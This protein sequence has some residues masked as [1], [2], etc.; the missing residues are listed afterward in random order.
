MADADPDL[1]DPKAPAGFWGVEPRSAEDDTPDINFRVLKGGAPES[2]RDL[3]SEAERALTIVKALYRRPEDAPKLR[4]AVAKLVA[5]SQVGLVGPNAS[6]AVA[7]DALRAL[8][9]DIIE[10]EAGPIKNQYMRKLGGWA[11]LFG[12][13][14]MV[15][16]LLCQH[17]PQ[18]LFE[19]F[20]RYR[21]VFLVW[22][23]SMAGAWASFASRKV[24]LGFADLVALEDDRIEPQLRLIFTGTLTTILALVFATGVA[25]V[26]VGSFRA[27]ALMH[28]GAVALLL[29]A[30]AGLSE[31]ALPSA[32]MARAGSVIAAVN[33]K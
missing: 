7:M 3:K 23:G 6:P 9:A 10:R 13:L 11:L 18:V 5:L 21:T 27:S 8:E 15:A 16:Y 4:E 33:P 2:Q 22:S 32:V 24:T 14:G 19:E 29:G 17:F 30:F 12:A 25:D 26:E 28:S 31:K 20:R 1:A